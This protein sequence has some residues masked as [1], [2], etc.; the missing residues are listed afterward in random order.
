MRCCVV[1]Y[2]VWFHDKDHP[3]NITWLPRIYGDINMTILLVSKR[4]PT[5][6]CLGSHQAPRQ[7]NYNFITAE[8]L[9][10][11]LYIVYGNLTVGELRRDEKFEL[12]PGISHF[13]QSVALS[14]KWLDNSSQALLYLESIVQ[15]AGSGS[16]NWIVSGSVAADVLGIR[17]N[18]TVHFP[19]PIRPAQN[20]T[21]NGPYTTGV[22]TLA[23]KTTQSSTPSKTTTTVDATATGMN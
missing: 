2:F 17:F 5:S 8:L 23:S 13:N 16:F 6:D 4:T 12:Y 11:H 9:R 10:Y 15:Q 3:F 18:T 22:A 20:G 7:T 19:L 21:T 14:G 1:L